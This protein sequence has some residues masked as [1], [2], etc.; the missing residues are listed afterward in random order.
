MTMDLHII[1]KT[2]IGVFLL[3]ALTPALTILATAAF[4]QVY[5]TGPASA[6]SP[7]SAG[8][9]INSADSGTSIPPIGPVKPSQVPPNASL[10]EVPAYGAAPLT[11]GFYVGLAN[12]PGA[13][14]YQ[15]NFGDGAVSVMP[16]NAYI[17]HVYQ[18]PGTYLCSLELIN[19]R[20][21]TTTVYA[22][23]T[24]KPAG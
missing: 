13:L 3:I 8:S 16:A 10:L 24:V 23:I 12:T 2:V 14:T 20:G 6:P 19:L 11:V 22:T 5:A 9:A 1:R 15:W 17:L 4:A 21:V 7:I 18:H